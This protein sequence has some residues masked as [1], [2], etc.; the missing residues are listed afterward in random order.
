MINKIRFNL[1]SEVSMSVLRKIARD[2]PLLETVRDGYGELAFLIE[3][4][5]KST[6]DFINEYEWAMSWMD[7]VTLGDE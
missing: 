7:F 6:T 2:F 4:N 3:L 5:N 1:R